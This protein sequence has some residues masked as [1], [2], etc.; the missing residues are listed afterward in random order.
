MKSSSSTKQTRS[1]PVVLFSAGCTL[2]GHKVDHTQIARKACTPCARCGAAILDLGPR[3]SRVAHTLSCFLGWHHYV[4]LGQRAEHNEYVCEKCGHSLLFELGADPYS[5]LNKFK[6]KVNYLC[7]LLGH[8]VHVV[9]KDSKATE[10]ACRCGHPFV[11][12]QT[13]LEVIRHPM[14]CVMLGHYITV[15]DTRGGWAEYICLRCG[16]PFYFRLTNYK[17]E[18][19]SNLEQP[20]HV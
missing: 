3:A 10:Y 9:K 14:S 7:G 4:A 15:N 16:H 8:R 18:P 6:K 5:K 2:V 19:E 12:E 11:K 1:L 20:L 17:L 13:A